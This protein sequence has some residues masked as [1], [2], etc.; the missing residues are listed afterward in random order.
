[1]GTTRYSGPVYGAKTLLFSCFDT[2][3][4]A[5][6]TDLEIFEINVPSDETWVITDV[7][8]YCDVQGNGG[9]VDVEDDGT[10]VLDANLTLVT[11]ASAEAT[12]TADAGEDEGTV[13]AAGSKITVDVTNGA[14]TAVDL[15]T[16]H[17]YGYIRK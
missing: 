10:S 15:L 13:V 1:M 11:K 7:Q 14:T 6:A 16:V 8:A 12:I 17:C 4:A 5:D 9:V 3:V 2:Q